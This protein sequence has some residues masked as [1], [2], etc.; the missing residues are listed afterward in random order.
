VSRA[1]RA[2]GLAV[3]ALVLL[4][5]AGWAAFA[6]WS[7][8]FGPTY[9]SGPGRG[10]LV[11]LTFDDGPGGTATARVLDILGRERVRATFF[12][13]GTNVRLHPAIAARLVREGHVVGNHTDTHPFWFGAGSTARARGEIDAAERA[14][15]AATGVY[16]HLFRPPQ[17]VRSPWLMRVLAADSLLAVTWDDAPRDW[18]RR[19][20]AELVASTLA[21]AHPGAIVLLHDGLNL[22]P[23]PDREATVAALPEIIRG[24]RARGY[25]FVTLPE[26]L[27]ERAYLAAWPAKAR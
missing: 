6:P 21:Q 1:P 7:S 12:L 13:V 20:A 19:S 17:G 22:D 25:R 3:A 16:P 11:A 9:W 18:E 8:A 15:H 14:I 26:L 2:A 27:G 24:L 10:R 23:R 5:A 4:G